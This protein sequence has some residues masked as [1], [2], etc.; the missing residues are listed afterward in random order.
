MTRKAWALWK[1]GI[2]DGKGTISTAAGVLRQTPRG[3]KPRLEDGEEANPEELIAAAHARCISV[4]LALVLD[5]AGWKAEKI[6][7][8]AELTLDKIGEAFEITRSHLSVV[9]AVPHADQAKFQQIANK[10]KAGC[11]VSKLLKARVTMEAK[12][13]S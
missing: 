13:V 10:A 9:A 1:G 4:A 6:E 7:T 11:P 3:F 2:K 5:D 8:H 12:L